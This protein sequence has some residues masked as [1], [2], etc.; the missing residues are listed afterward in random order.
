MLDIN[1]IL[2]ERYNK[3]VPKPVNNHPGYDMC[4]VCAY[5]SNYGPVNQLEKIIKIEKQYDSLLV[6][7]PGQSLTAWAVS[8]RIQLQEL[9]TNQRF[10][11]YYCHCLFAGFGNGRIVNF[12]YYCPRIHKSQ[13][14]IYFNC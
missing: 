14:I 11:V 13:M 3:V 2:D 12:E 6:V 7:K 8:A 10:S 5:I 1:I 4:Y 9:L